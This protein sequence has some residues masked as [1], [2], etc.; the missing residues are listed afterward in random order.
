MNAVDHLRINVK[1][2]IRYAVHF[3]AAQGCEHPL[4]IPISVMIEAVVN[5]WEE[6]QSD[7]FSRI[8]NHM[9][10]PGDPTLN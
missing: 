6:S 2:A 10:Y 1:V 8:S 9:F 4:S 7:P 3:L 5:G